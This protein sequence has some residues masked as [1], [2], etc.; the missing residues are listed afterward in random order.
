VSLPPPAVRSRWPESR[1]D[2]PIRRR[3]RR[4]F[5]VAPAIVLAA[6]SFATAQQ[7]LP[8]GTVADRIVIEKRARRLSLY[9]AGRVLKTYRVALGPNPTGHKQQEGD[10]RTPEGMYTIDFRKR[11]S[12]FHRALHISYPNAADLRRARERGVSPGGDIMIHGLPN[13]SRGVGAN[14]ARR[15]WT[16]GCIAV[17]SEEIEE[18]WRVVLNGTP[19]EIR[20]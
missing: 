4:L 8:A 19:V 17:T 10:G 14:H 20:P 16:L 6:T 7:P 13:G 3:C 9:H 5:T 18:I 15:D 12:A 11:D 2:E 1:R